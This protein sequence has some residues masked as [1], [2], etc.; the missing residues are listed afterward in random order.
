MNATEIK[1]ALD[2]GNTVKAMDGDAPCFISEV[3]YSQK[4]NRLEESV[5]CCYS[6]Y[7]AKIHDGVWLDIDEL[8]NIEVAA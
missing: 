6:A 7:Q 4:R 5:R 2:N 1:T 8:T 3:F